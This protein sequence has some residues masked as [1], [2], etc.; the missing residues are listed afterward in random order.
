LDQL[1]AGGRG[2]RHTQLYFY[3]INETIANRVKRSPKLDTTLIR[4]ILGIVEAN[5]YVLLFRSLGSVSNI[6]EHNIELNTSISVDQRRYN[7][8][9]MDQ[10]TAIWVD[11]NN[12]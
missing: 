1:V 8:P 9:G 7:A 12:P 4:L 11:G 5:P 6:A 3:D 2:P 10:V